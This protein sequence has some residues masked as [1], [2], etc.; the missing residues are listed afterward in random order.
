MPAVTVR[1][2]PPVYAAARRAAT[3]RGL[4]LAEWVRRCIDAGDTADLIRQIHA[5][6]VAGAAGLGDEGA[7]AVEALTQL[8]LSAAT[9]RQRVKAIVRTHPDKPACA[10]ITDALRKESA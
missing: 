1:L 9:A 10:I 3:S 7:A 4:S 5:A 6:V 2:P 8:G